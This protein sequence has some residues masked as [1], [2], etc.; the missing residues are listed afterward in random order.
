MERFMAALIGEFF[1]A[2]LALGGVAYIWLGTLSA[3]R[4]Y[5][6]WPRF[7]YWSAAAVAAL[8]G[9]ATAASSGDPVLY[10]VVTVAVCAFIV[11]RERRA[12]TRRP[13]S[14]ASPS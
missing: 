2:L 7:S 8:V 13:V 1:G 14:S 12:L 11:I 10:A 5:K 9:A 3:M 6:R 4:V